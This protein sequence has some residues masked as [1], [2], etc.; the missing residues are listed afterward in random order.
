[1][2]Q[3]IAILHYADVRNFGDVLFPLLVAHEVRSRLPDAE[4]RFINATGDTWAGIQSV[5]LDHAD[6]KSLDAAI[7]GGGEI[8]H[9]LDAMLGGIYARFG[10][11]AVARP[12][13]LVFAWTH[14]PLRHK[15]W[16]GLGVPEPAADVQADIRSASA[17]LTLLTARGSLSHERLVRS[18]VP[19]GA[20]RRSPDLGWLFPRLLRGRAAP[21]PA[22]HGEPYMV[23]H[24]L[25]FEDP[26]P[27]AHCLSRFAQRHA[28][29]VVLLPLTRCWGDVEP[30]RWLNQA[31]GGC[32]T[33]VDDETADL[34]KLAILGGAV[35]QVGQSMHGF[36]GSMAQNR[37]AGLVMPLQPD[38]FTELLDDNDWP[39]LRCA[40]W[41]G[42]DGLLQT[43]LWTPPTVMAGARR[44][45][46]QALDG[47][48]D[49]LC[50]GIAADS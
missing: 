29:R 5:R 4:L 19:P 33:L 30:L 42:L 9:R 47:L 34:D 10:L 8:V 13:D 40:G 46:E 35:L 25:G 44:R 22:G 15:A 41:E 14:A 17:G 26:V 21:T 18:G 27:V 7:L 3:K 38:K 39:Q 12:T 20:V 50:A 45:H 32:Y 11:Q 24:A 49:E 31:A 1:M 6:L 37:P 48:F 43:L 36:I 16:L 23:V 2:P 28:L